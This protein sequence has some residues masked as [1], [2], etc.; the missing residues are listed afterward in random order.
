MGIEG[1]THSFTQ[2]RSKRLRDR[3]V[4]LEDHVGEGGNSRFDLVNERAKRYSSRRAFDKQRNNNGNGAGRRIALFV[5]K[6]MAAQA[7]G[8][9]FD[10]DTNIRLSK[11]EACL[12]LTRQ[13]ATALGGL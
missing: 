12:S 10:I 2:A 6:C 13:A 3:L 8:G 11:I 7:A 5:R 4:K 9:R 1:R